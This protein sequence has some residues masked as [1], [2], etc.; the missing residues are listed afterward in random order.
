MAFRLALQAVP[1]Q[2]FSTLLD[3]VAYR[4]TIKATR[5]IMS[6]SISLDDVVIV[7]GSRFFTDSPLIPYPHLE[8][9]GGNFIF[10]SAADALPA[11]LEFDITQFLI[12]VT[13]KEIADA[14]S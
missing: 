14:R 6:V 2:S 11:F 7:S 12:Y 8:G 5:G 4:L 10:I 13:V 3:G 1:N 9:S